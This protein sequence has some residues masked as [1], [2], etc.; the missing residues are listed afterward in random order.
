MEA[1]ARRAVTRGGE[2]SPATAAM[3]SIAALRRAGCS[4]IDVARHGAFQ[5]E[6]FRLFS[7]TASATAR[8]TAERARDA[9]VS[10]MESS[11][12]TIGTS[13][14]RVVPTLALRH[15]G[16]SWSDVVSHPAFK[17]LGK[18]RDEVLRAVFVGGSG[19]IARSAGTRVSA[20]AAAK[21]KRERLPGPR[22]PE[23][24]EEL[25]YFISSSQA[26]R[27]AGCSWI[28]VARHGAFH[29]C[30]RARVV[31]GGYSV[32]LAT[33][34][35]HPFTTALATSVVKCV[36]SD[37]LVQKV[38][39]R[40]EELDAKRTFCFFVLGLTYVGAFQYGLYNHLI[41]PA[42]DALTRISGSTGASV[43][44]M[45]AID[46]LL[47]CPLLYLP[48]F[49][50]LKSWA[51]GECDAAQVPAR[52]AVRSRET[53]LVGANAMKNVSATGHVSGARPEKSASMVS[54]IVPTGSRIDAPTETPLED[55]SGWF[56][57]LALWAYWVPAQAVNFWVVPRHLTIPFMNVAGFGWNGIMSAMNGSALSSSDGFEDVDGGASE[58]ASTRVFSEETDLA[59]PG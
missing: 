55:D 41:K 14:R 50:G 46:Q 54:A 8:Q 19:P 4:L 39:E 1:A 48:A 53:L 9:F 23:I 32:Y 36:A 26:L 34:V 57:L 24:T 52:M 44:L 28:D 21:A 18:E 59:A 38:I 10:P 12:K 25:A 11:L 13:L 37:V 3:T 43:G 17:F 40:K 16:G 35:R 33:F 20:A 30:I 56:T 58:E 6:A 31:A 49:F 15:A 45:V 7:A 42:G 2:L 22:F 5:K 27:H 47:V 51:S 29:A